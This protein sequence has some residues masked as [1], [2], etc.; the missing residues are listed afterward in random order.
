MHA[1]L[2]SINLV[3]ASTYDTLREVKVEGRISDSIEV[4]IEFV[5]SHGV[6]SWEERE[7]ILMRTT[8][9]NRFEALHS[10]IVQK[11]DWAFL[12]LCE[13]LDHSGHGYI[14]E[15]FTIQGT[16]IKKN[17]TYLIIGPKRWTRFL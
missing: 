10:L 9:V 17:I 2:V 3:G 1:G 16:D 11:G 8:N 4:T 13:G 6:I 14:S 5:T 12:V 15:M 7:T